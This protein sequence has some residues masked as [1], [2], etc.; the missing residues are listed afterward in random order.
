MKKAP[1]APHSEQTGVRI[2]I[3]PSVLQRM[4]QSRILVASDIH[5]LDSLSKQ[6]LWQA[7]LQASK[8]EPY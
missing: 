8:P 3:S 1:L 6:C 4:I 5:C 2:E 7:C